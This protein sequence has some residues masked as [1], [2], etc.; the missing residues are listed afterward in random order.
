[1]ARRYDRTKLTDGTGGFR[2]ARETGKGTGN[3]KDEEH[4]LARAETRET[5]CSRTLTDHLDLKTLQRVL[6]QEPDDNRCN[7]RKDEAPMRAARCAPDFRQNGAIAELA[8]F[9]EII[10]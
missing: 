6:E 7:E 8:S 10:S 2:D 5:P 4:Y 9:R 1:V 3:R